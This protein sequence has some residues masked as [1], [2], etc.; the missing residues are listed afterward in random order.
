MKRSIPLFIIDNSRAHGRARETDYVYCS[1]RQCPW[2][3]EIT[4]LTEA[5]LA[6]DQDWANKDPLCLYSEPNPAGIR[7]KLKVLDADNT[8]SIWS[9]MRRCL[10]EWMKR[11]A[12]TVVDTDDVSDKAV[13]RFA[14]T[15]LEQTRE[16]LRENPNDE[17]A[18][19]VAAILTKI[20]NDY[21]SHT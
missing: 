9:L 19:M 7:A 14:E 12:V 15:L 20:K 10:R 11:R 16:N 1:S 18:K 8:I 6:I 5:E 2:V 21:E 3:G 17:Q 4:L 13:A